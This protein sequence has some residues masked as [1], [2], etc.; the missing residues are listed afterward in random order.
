M[1]V[2][3][4]NIRDKEIRILGK[5]FVK[6]NKGNCKLLINKKEYDLCEFIKKDECCINTNNDLLSII[7]TGTNIIINAKEKFYDCTSLITLPDIFK[8][9]TNNVTNMSDMFYQCSSLQ[10]LLYISKWDT[11]NVT[12]MSY[13]F[14]GCS[15]L[16]S[17]PDISKWDT[18]KVTN[19]DYI[20]R[21]CK[22]F[23]KTPI[24]TEEC[25]IY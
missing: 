4:N 12:D 14:F 19:I 2:Y 9:D 25:I 10:S 8:W 23:P 21:R 20:F 16:K 22:S 24:K 18:K 11:Q 17:L 6:N 7:L 1:I 15:S 13:M 5:T 3:K